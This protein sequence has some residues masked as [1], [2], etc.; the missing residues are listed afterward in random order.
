VKT[1]WVACWTAGRTD[2]GGGVI[3]AARENEHADNKT[4]RMSRRINPG[5]LGMSTLKYGI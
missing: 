4:A 1:D 2:P 3:S 5:N